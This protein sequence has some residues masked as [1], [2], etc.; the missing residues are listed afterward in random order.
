M[1]PDLLRERED[2]VEI[3]T[4][5]RKFQASGRASNEGR[6]L[7]MKDLRNLTDLTKHDV[8]YISVRER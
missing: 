2:F 1:R 4:S 8:K 3:M 7:E 6:E 5:E